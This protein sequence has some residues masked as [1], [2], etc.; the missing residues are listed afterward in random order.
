MSGA[1][2]LTAEQ[3]TKRQEQS[4]AIAQRFGEFDLADLSEEQFER[5]LD[6]MKT[7]LARVEKI[8]KTRLVEDVHFG[9]P[10]DKDGKPVKSIKKPFLYQAGAEEL[11]QIYRLTLKHTPESPKVVSSKEHVDVT[12]TL[13]I[14][15]SFGHLIAQ[16]SANCNTREKRFQKYDGGWIYTDARE[17]AHNCIAM[18]EKRAG[19]FLTREATGASGYFTNPEELER[20]VEA[21]EEA[22]VV[23]VITPWTEDEKTKVYRA[24]KDIGIK[25]ADEFAKFALEVLGRKE[26]GTGEDVAKL[27]AEVELRKSAPGRSEDA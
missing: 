18:A 6:R 8:C 23:S 7:R 12:V 26:I 10:K 3:L 14:Y 27:L 2:G 1:G 19:V 20:A 24:V 9:I 5:E 13:G 21:A 15:N 16:R 4:A 11:R 25:T 22:E 17:Q